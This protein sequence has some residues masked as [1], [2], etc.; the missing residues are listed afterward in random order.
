MSKVH[1][2]DIRSQ[3]AFSSTLN[4]PAGPPVILTTLNIDRIPAKPIIDIPSFC[5]HLQNLPDPQTV[6]VINSTDFF[7]K[8]EYY[9][10]QNWLKKRVFDLEVSQNKYS[11]ELCYSATT[12][13][14]QINLG[15]HFVD[16]YVLLTKGVQKKILL[17][18]YHGF[19]HGCA[20]H[21]TVK[22]PNSPKNIDRREISDAKDKKLQEYADV[23]A[24]CTPN[25]TVEIVIARPCDVQHKNIDNVPRL[26]TDIVPKRQSYTRF[27]S[28]VNNKQY[29]GFLVVKNLQL[30]KENRHPSMGFCVQRSSID[31]ETMY[32][33]Y[34]ENNYTTTKKTTAVLG[35]H[36][37]KHIKVI[38]TSYF[39]YLKE[40][41]GFEHEPLIL[42]AVLFKHESYLKQDIE[43]HLELRAEIKEKLKNP[44]L[45]EAEKRVLNS[46]SS[47]AKLKLNG[48]YGFT[49]LKEGTKIHDSINI[50]IF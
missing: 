36:E 38:H 40:H 7:F 49:L 23:W 35:L 50:F 31:P 33:A 26:L 37:F 22:D 2:L 29:E 20:I 34:M 12:P 28:Q 15:R 25:L 46:E 42:H 30:K 39:H 21:C 5:K 48:T 10:V 13:M 6:E 18:Q 19:Y 32:S 3:Y 11:L 1:G 27:V 24:A 44:N 47:S 9:A 43:H 41:F 16:C 45:S 14:G 8:E 4:L 17:F